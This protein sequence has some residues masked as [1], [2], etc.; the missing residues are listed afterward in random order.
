MSW[1]EKSV[2]W[3]QSRE[4]LVPESEHGVTSC[5][6]SALEPSCCG[7]FATSLLQKGGRDPDEQ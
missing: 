1:K 6:A 3:K 7:P 4:T 2:D 5:L